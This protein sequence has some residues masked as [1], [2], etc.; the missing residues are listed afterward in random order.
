MVRGTPLHAASRFG[1]LEMVELILAHVEEKNLRVDFTGR[2]PF[3]FA[4][5][6]GHLDI[7]QLIMEN[8]EDRS[9]HQFHDVCLLEDINDFPGGQ[10]NHRSYE[11]ILIYFVPSSSFIVLVWDP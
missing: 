7:V 10:I 9:L 1:H 5:L 8:I 3:H 6:N 2:T 4:A 11:R